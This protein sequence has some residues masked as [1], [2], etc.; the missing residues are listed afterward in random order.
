MR[1][2]TEGHALIEGELAWS[3]K[4]SVQV[5]SELSSE[6]DKDPLMEGRRRDRH[7]RQRAKHLEGTKVEKGLGV[8][9]GQH[10]Y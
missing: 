5:T 3:Q 10:S 1:K 4:T 6:D 8:K 7:C 9:R 2:H